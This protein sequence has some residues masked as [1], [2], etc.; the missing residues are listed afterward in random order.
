[1]VSSTSCSDSFAAEVNPAA[2]SAKTAGWLGE[3]RD[4]NTFS[5]SPYSGLSGI[6]SLIVLMIARA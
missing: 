2:K 4:R 1:M 3:D 6:S 5:S